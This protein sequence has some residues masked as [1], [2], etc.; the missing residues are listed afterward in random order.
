MPALARPLLLAILPGNPGDAVFYGDFAR[1]LEARGHEVLVASHLTL[2]APPASLLPYAA[3]QV[4]AIERHLAATGRSLAEVELVLLGHSVGAYLAYLIV[5][6]RLL[7]VSRVFMLCPFLARPSLSARLLLKLV[8][9]RRLYGG[10]LR[11]WRRGPPKLRRLLVGAAGVGAHEGWVQAALASTEPLS[12]A[13]MA[14]AEAAEIA[15]RAQVSY[16]FEEPL[17]QD[18]RRFLAV[19]TPDDRWAPRAWSDP[20]A[21]ACL[22]LAGIS[23]AFV[24][25]PDQCQ[26]VAGVVHER[27][28]TEPAMTA[29]ATQ[30]TAAARLP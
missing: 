2:T 6:H 17:F 21:P 4:E 1:A 9:S 11:L 19:L 5:K 29:A 20:R 24:L 27:L 28:A 13:A 10:G 12:W 14:T 26:A 16:L 3:H 7:P 18:P 30:R 25:E 23:H 15:S 22:W 8:T